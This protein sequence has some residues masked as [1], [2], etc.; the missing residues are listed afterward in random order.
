MATLTGKI[1]IVTGAASGMG[2]A[3]CAALADRGATVIGV[4]IARCDPEDSPLK[5]KNGYFKQ[6]NVTKS[7]EWEILVDEA[8]YE[9]GVLDVLVNCAGILVPGTIDD[10]SISDW[11][12]SMAVNVDGVFYGCRA[13]IRVM[14]WNV[15][16]GSI[17]N[18]VSTSSMYADANLVAYDASK[19]AACSLTKELSVYCVHKGY[20]I[21]CNSIHPGTIHTPMLDHFF[22]EN[23]IDDELHDAWMSGTPLG[24]SG[25]PEEVGSL[26]AFLASDRSRYMNGSECVIDGGATA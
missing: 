1:A 26:V 13:A 15:N 20:R 9:Y 4:D 3:S 22:E 23:E 19:G 24:R 16:G 14:R 2:R 6:L 7:D 8:I 11:R 17:I 5:G 12:R 25:T 10:I 21:R 18:I